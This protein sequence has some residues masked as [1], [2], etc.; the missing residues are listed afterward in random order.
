MLFQALYPEMFLELVDFFYLASFFKEFAIV[1]PHTH[2]K[3]KIRTDVAIP[4]YHISVSINA[5]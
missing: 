4:V 2:M 5:L 3:E 1:C